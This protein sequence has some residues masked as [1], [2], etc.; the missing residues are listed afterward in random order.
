[1]FHRIVS[2]FRRHSRAQG[3]VEFALALPILLLLLF[4]IIEFGRLLLTYASV[5]NAAR[6]AVRY[7]ATVGNNAS[8]TPRYQDCAGMRQQAMS[9]S[10]FAGLKTTDIDLRY[11]I[12]P[13]DTRAWASKPQCVQGVSEVNLGDRVVVRVSTL[14]SPIVPLAI[15]RNFNVTSDAARTVL[16]NIEV[17]GTPANSPTPKATRTPTT[18]ATNTS[19]PTQTA[20]PTI[21]TSTVT[22]TP[23]FTQTP[24]NT[25]TPTN[26]PTSTSTATATATSTPTSTSTATSTICPPNVCG[27]TATRTSTPTNTATATA[28]PLPTIPACPNLISYPSS[29]GMTYYINIQNMDILLT[30]WVESITLT[31]GSGGGR[32]LVE[33]YYDSASKL[34]TPV[35]TILSPFTIDE[36]NWNAS[37][38]RSYPP[39]HTETLNFI[40]G[41]SA[42]VSAFVITFE[43]SACICTTTGCK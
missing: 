1:M 12:G 21:Y 14:Y 6:E 26:T 17:V 39:G 24:T 15:T 40:F 4:A 32:D 2:H 30:L 37:G 34:F 10:F 36:T 13:E 19:T 22:Q 11:D 33:V 38:A 7:G 28:T 5:Y 31:W 3:M 23:T 42:T 25:G 35:D 43:N 29:G 16:R 8:G 41:K 27:P 9:T 18:T 20:T